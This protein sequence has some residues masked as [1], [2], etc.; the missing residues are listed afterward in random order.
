MLGEGREEAARLYVPP[1][2]EDNERLDDPEA[3]EDLPPPDVERGTLP[4]WLRESSKSFRWGWVPL[5]LRKVGRA[6]A[7]WVKGP[8][9]PHTLMLK[10][11]FPRVQELP[12]QYLDRLFPKRKF[13]TVLLLLLYMSWFLPWFLVLL[14][15]RSSGY[16][17]GYGRPQ[18]LSCL[19]NFWY[20]LI[21]ADMCRNRTR[22]RYNVLIQLL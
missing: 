9:P 2:L 14:H 8:D 15:S 18:T 21:C 1:L 13:K 22:Y 5:P 12:V 11:L 19:T 10:P 6:T 20:V 16:I 4:V 7:N 17:E 3:S